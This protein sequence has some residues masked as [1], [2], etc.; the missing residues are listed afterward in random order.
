[1]LAA[2]EIRGIRYCALHARDGQLQAS[3]FAIHPLDQR[4]LATAFAD[5]KEL[6]ILTVQA[7]DFANQ[8]RRIVFARS[9]GWRW[10]IYAVDFVWGERNG[11]PVETILER[12]HRE[13][14]LWV[15]E[16]APAGEPASE[17]QAP[18]TTK[19]SGSGSCIVFLGPDGV[20]KTTLLRAISESLRAVFP[21]QLIYRWRPAVFAKAPRLA[22]LPH[23]KPPRSLWGSFSYLF[24]TWLDFTTGYAFAIRSALSRNA[25]IIF[26][27]NYHD[28]LVDPKRY[29]FGGPLWLA[30]A[31]SPTVPPYE[32]FFVVLD[33]N[34]QTILS[35]KQQLPAEEIRRQ[36][37]AYR[38]FAGQA[39]ASVLISTERELE[40]CR[41]EALTAIFRYLADKLS[42]RDPKWFGAGAEPQFARQV[43]EPPRPSAP[44]A[45]NS[46]HADH[47]EYKPRLT[48]PPQP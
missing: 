48:A 21:E 40:S 39:S 12:R 42:A 47:L 38:E 28:L 19:G 1:M 34:E 25:L 17:N 2:F 13:G 45:Q 36:R 10:Q 27:R 9:S 4:K 11:V 24:F 18:Q 15:T 14:K 31:L 35:R 37:Q 23:S 8:E 41:S 44:A 7:I 29:R 6:G 16:D 5:L 32:V 33:A 26:D 43:A 22:R 20:G 46:L 30:K 3:E